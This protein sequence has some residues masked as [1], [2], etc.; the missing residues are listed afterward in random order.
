MNQKEFLNS[1]RYLIDQVKTRAEKNHSYFFSIDT[2]R[3]F[4]SRVSGLMW[5]EGNLKDYQT[6]VIYFI[7]SEADKSNFKHSGSIR[8]YTIR[9]CD[10][11][12]DIVTIGKFQEF[13]TLNSARIEIK[14]IMEL[15][16]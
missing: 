13:K 15:I 11:N 6:E 8:A 10:A 3:F 14:D 5:S 16:K 4:S 9:K 2:M 7:T 1:G 12:G